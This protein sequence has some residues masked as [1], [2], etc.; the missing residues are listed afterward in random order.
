M[1]ESWYCACGLW[2]LHSTWEPSLWFANSLE[3]FVAGRVTV[4]HV[5]HY[6]HLC[7]FKTL[8][9]TSSPWKFSHECR[10]RVRLTRSDLETPDRSPLGCWGN[11]FLVKITCFCSSTWDCIHVLRLPFG[12]PQMLEDCFLGRKFW[13]NCSLSCI[14]SGMD[15]T[16][17]RKLLLFGP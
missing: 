8:L 6:C 17:P 15:F 14:C 5:P 3:T 2:L 11:Q 4:P 7:S 13:S 12:R 9:L 1:L 16:L 10:M